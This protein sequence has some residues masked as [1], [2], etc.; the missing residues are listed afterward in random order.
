VRQLINFG[1]AF[2][3]RAR[4]GYG[5]GAGHFASFGLASVLIVLSIF[6]MWGALS[7]YRAGNAARHYSELSDAFEQARFAVATEESLNR[8]YRLQPSAEVRG[9]H[10]EAATSLLAALERARVV[11]DPA[12]GV[13]ISDVLAMHKE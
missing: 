7:T 1:K 4:G 3:R 10:Q 8:K 5:L 2:F 13:L 6:V 11:G 9:R 12:D